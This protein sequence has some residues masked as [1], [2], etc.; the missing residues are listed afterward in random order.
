VVIVPF[1]SGKASI[2]ARLS[3]NPVAHQVQQWLEVLAAL[4]DPCQ[5]L[6]RDLYT[7]SAQ[8]RLEVIQR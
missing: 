6:A 1:R 4:D 2:T 5:G 3:S 7:V 8:Y